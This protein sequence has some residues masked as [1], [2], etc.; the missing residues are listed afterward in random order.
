MRDAESTAG[1]CGEE[2]CGSFKDV[3]YGSVVILISEM[4]CLPSPEVG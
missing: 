4:Q 1:S 3:A 2:S